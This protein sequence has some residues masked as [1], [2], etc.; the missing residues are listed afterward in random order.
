MQYKE[1]LLFVIDGSKGIKK[2]IE[3]QFSQQALIQRC[4]WHKQENVLS[5]L[6]KNLHEEIKKEYHQ[7]LCRTTY[8]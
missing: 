3:E 1:G 6:T 4:T 8:K 7:A 5:Y 2:A